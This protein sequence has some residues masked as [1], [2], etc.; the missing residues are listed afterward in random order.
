MLHFQYPSKEEDLVTSNQPEWDELRR[1][2]RKAVDDV[3]DRFVVAANQEGP[4][5]VTVVAEG[6]VTDHW[7]YQWPSRNTEQFDYA[8]WYRVNGSS[9]NVRVLL[10]HTTRTV[11]GEDLGRWIVFG[12]LG[13]EDSNTFY[14][15][16][17]FV[18][19]DDGDFA[20][21]IPNPTR[22]RAGLRDGDSLPARY[23]QARV[24]RTDELHHT[25]ADGP[26]LRFVVSLGNAED[27]IRHG[28]WV[29][30]LRH[31]LHG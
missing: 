29:A 21:I 1:E 25:V 2:L 26:S 9:G 17:E 12:Q 4:D 24:R 8:R 20:A 15:W 18:E 16:T 7:T 28:Y 14:P 13:G 11:R 31:R 27:M 10:A 30:E 22:P 5:P 6:D 19:T 23:A 3:L